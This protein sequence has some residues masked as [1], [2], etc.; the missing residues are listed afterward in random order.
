VW[1]VVRQKLFFYNPELKKEENFLVQEI[2]SPFL[3]K[4]QFKKEA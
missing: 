3:P 2:S 4:R 1:W